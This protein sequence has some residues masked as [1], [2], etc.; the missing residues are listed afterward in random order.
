MKAQGTKYLL[1]DDFIA[2]KVAEQASRHRVFYDS[3]KDAPR[4][5]GVRVTKN[6]AVSFVLNYYSCGAER[7]KTIGAYGKRGQG[8]MTI[9]LARRAGADLRSSVLS[10]KDPLAD[11]RAAKASAKAAEAARKAREEHTLAALV[12]AYVSDMRAHGKASAEQVEALFER[13]VAAPFPKIA[14]L[15][16]A[17]VTVDAVM[18]VFHKMTKAGMKRDPEKLASYLRTAFNAAKRARIDARGHAYSDFNVRFNPLDDLRVSRP[19]VTPDAARKAKQ[20]EL[21]LSESQLAA[22]WKRISAMDDAYGAL[23]RLHLLTGGQRREQLC[24]LTRPDYDNASKTITL[25]DAKGRRSVAR[26]HILPLLPEAIEAIAVMAGANGSYLCS[27]TDGKQPVTP[28]VLDDAMKRA[29]EPMVEA[30]EIPRIITP[31][32]IRRTVETRLGERNVSLEVRAQL[33]SHGLGGV[34]ARHYDRGDYLKQKREALEL[35]RALCEPK[36]SRKGGAAKAK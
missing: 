27:V 16:V 19:P 6:G 14:A 5:F 2:E 11:E 17:D 18:P 13:A 10:G 36:N 15:P 7:R 33:Q 30:G 24:R 31:G 29:S 8:G 12:R 4:G 3:H 32:V 23:L 9:A 26:E 1:T 34:Q 35:L 20:E 25:W 28:A 21:T 22:Y